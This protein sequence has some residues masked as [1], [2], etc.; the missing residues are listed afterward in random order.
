[1][2]FEKTVIDSHL[3][4]YDW[5]NE[6]GKTYFE[7]FDDY[8]NRF[9][10]KAINLC[11]TPFNYDDISNNILGALYK[12]HN[13]TA[14]AYAG[15]MYAD[16]PVKLPVPKGFETETQYRELKEIGFDGIKLM[17]SKPLDEKLLKI[18]VADGYYEDLFSQAEKDG[19]HIIWHVA[20]PD[21]FW[22]PERIPGW[23]RERG[24]TYF[25]GTFATLENL[26]GDVFKVLER[27]PKLNVTFAH[28]F[29][30][31]EEPEKL[32]EIFE[33]YPNVTIDLVPGS[34]MYAGFQKNREKYN[35]FFVKYAD[36]ILYGTDISFPVAEDT[37]DHLA[38]EVYRAVATDQTVDI[39]NVKCKGFELPDDVCDKILYKNF[40]DKCRQKPNKINVEALKKYVE[41]YRPY[42][43]KTERLKLIDEFLAKY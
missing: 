25:D 1:M 43:Q 22:D 32:E 12:L 28:F 27:H 24:W 42:I 21:F 17:E 33:K 5:F 20:D 30:L 8:Q 23:A 10:F 2:K 11:M 4:L 38:T 26:Y 37:W 36:R 14:Y 31:S 15:V 40:T 16:L 9:G 13:P 7:A 39:Y 35:E 29:F 41:K 6:D 18:S 3:H 19:T 34:E